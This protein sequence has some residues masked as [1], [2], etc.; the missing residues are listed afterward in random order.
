MTARLDMVSAEAGRYLIPSL[1]GK[2]ALVIDD[3]SVNRGAF[4]HEP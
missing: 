2:R 4:I 3:T 1:E